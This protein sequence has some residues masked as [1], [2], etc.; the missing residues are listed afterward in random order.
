MSV[1]TNVNWTTEVALRSPSRFI[2]TVSKLTV[3]F[4]SIDVAFVYL[5]LM[6][7]FFNSDNIFLL[8]ITMAA[9]LAIII[10]IYLS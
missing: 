4:L 8:M 5:T 6:T 10:L 2:F 7:I 9:Q 3:R 1:T